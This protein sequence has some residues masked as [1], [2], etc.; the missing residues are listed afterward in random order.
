CAEK[1]IILI[2]DLAHSVG[3]VY[4]SGKEAGAFGD[5]TVFSFSQDKIIDGIS[6]GALV[7][8]NPRYRIRAPYPLNDLDYKT[9]LIERLYPLFTFK[10]RKTYGVGL[11]KILHAALKKARLLSLP[12]GELRQRGL[13]DLPSWYC[14]LAKFQFDN[15]SAN[16]AHRR[17][18]ASVYAAKLDKSVLPS[19][20][21]EQL[22]LSNNLR[23]PIFVNNRE[24]L[25]DH[26]MKNKV[27]V[28]DI[29]YDA[30][31][32]PHKYLHLTNY[33]Q[34]QCPLAEKIAFRI[35]NLPT[36]INVSEKEADRITELIN[37]WSSDDQK[38]QR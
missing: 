19:F 9:Q 18:I 22:S 33:Q 32:S 16:V 23:F 31:I 24:G 11:G 10:I 35:L 37:Q 2:E 34:G 25:I 15:L 12:L 20:S 30:P 7:I 14:H 21:I 4:G 26:L 5:F 13:Y 1:G 28:S 29:W 3:A 6:G 38:L 17:S 36:H 8:K 27:F